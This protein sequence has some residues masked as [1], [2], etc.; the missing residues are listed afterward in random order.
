MVLSARMFTGFGRVAHGFGR[1]ALLAAARQAVSDA[2]GSVRALSGYSLLTGLGLLLGLVREL[3][4]ASTFG[5]SPQLDVFVA[6][7]TV[8]LFF[9]AQVGNALETAFIG[10]VASQGS[11]GTVLRTLRPAV[12][13]VLLVNAGIVL[14]LSL[15][16]ALALGQLFPRFDS[17]QQALATHL[18]SALFVPMVCASTAG[19]LRGGLVVLGAFVP[20]F[21]AGSLVSVCTIASVL[22][23]SASLGIDALTLGVAA[24]NL[25]V[26]MLYLGRLASLKRTDT[27]DLPDLPPAKKRDGWFLLWGA[28]TMVLAGELVYAGVALTER[29]LASGL[30][31]GS[32]AAFFYASTIVSVPLSLFV[33]PLTAM[34]FPR[35]VE[36]FARDMRAGVAQVRRHGVL[37]LAASGAVVMIVSLFAQPIV[38]TVFLRGRFS[39][40]DA[41]LTASIL[42]VTIFSL[43][44]ISLSRLIRNS[45]YSL[46]D[47]RTPVMGMSVQLMTLASAG[48]L[49]MPRFGSQGLAVAM[50]AGEAANL[51]T[52]GLSLRMRMYRHG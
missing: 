44:F 43:P 13:G 33:V 42:A 50:V 29:S 1:S 23:F 39:I 22:L 28:A 35:M 45:S 32:I 25:A 36:A 52:M 12:Y 6:V 19:L 20:G 34:V 3:T 30:P 21:V 40:E 46:S 38:E 51:M 2:A 17:A 26:L 18:L 41:R 49:L 11:V 27:A 47:Y 7:M 14:C 37:L 5:L 15:S 10:R 24:G 4:V 16:G 8:Q 9:G 48:L 31:A